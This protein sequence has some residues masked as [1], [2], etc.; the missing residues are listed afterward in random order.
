MLLKNALL[1]ALLESEG[2][3]LS[4]SAL[5]TRLGVSRT[6]IWKAAGL[7]R[8]EGYVIEAGPNRGYRLISDNDRLSE[9]AIR[10][11]LTG[12]GFGTEIH[13]YSELTSTNDKAKE[14]AN[15]GAVDGTVVI[16][17]SQSAGKGRRGRSFF[18][19]PGSGLY[20]SVILRPRLT[21]EQAS[22]IT[23]AAAVAAARAV[24]R[25]ASL[26]G[27]TVGIKWVNDLY[28][29]GRKICGILTEAALDLESG[30]LDYAVLGIG[31]N[32]A[33]IS[34][35]EELRRT[36]ELERELPGVGEPSPCRFLEES[37]RRSVVVGRDVLVTKGNETFSARALE[38][39]D[40]G[41]LVVET[42]AGRQTLRSG[43][44][45]VHLPQ[46]GETPADAAEGSTTP[47]GRS[48]APNRR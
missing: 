44:V 23:S 28:I 7:L 15:A 34:F 46:D 40:E 39:D 29:R 9:P 8:E 4:G 3:S 41:G 19:P 16:A 48:G 22:R 25:A 17:D 11:L 10:R 24:E 27:G 6:A 2:E 45:S 26:P 33:P 42:P 5:A 13:L 12:T 36:D 37:R 21:G 31:I 14:L 32:T 30:L 18:S 47:A 20:L 1:K 38:I 43:E 35:P